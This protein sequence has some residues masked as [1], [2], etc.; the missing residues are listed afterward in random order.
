MFVN[1]E[2]KTTM[3]NIFAYRLASAR[4]MAGLSLQQLSDLLGTK[5]VSKQALNKYE[6][7]KMKPESS[8]LVALANALGVSVDYFFAKPNVK[9]V[10]KDV[11]YRKFITKISKPVQI[12]IEEKA[13]AQFERYFDLEE[14]LQL[15]DKRDYFKYNKPINTAKDAEEAAKTLRKQWDL[16]YDAVPDVVEML[17]DKGYKVIEL[18]AQEGFDGLSATINGEPVIALN[19]NKN[20]TFDIVRKRFSAL[21]ELAHHAL[22]FPDEMKEKEQEKLCHAFASAVLYPEEMAKKELHKERFHFYEKELILLKERWGLSIAAIFSRAKQ[23]GIINDNTY[24]RF[25]IGYR[26]RE[27]HKPGKE[28]GRFLSKE[29]PTRMERLV[30]LGLAKEVLSIN[31]AA[32]F[33]GISAWELRKQMD[34]L[35]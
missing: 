13:K 5:G 7:G 26:T 10:L 21:H 33:A 9:I 20:E 22:V 3:E 27:Y 30:F 4:K 18:D 1:N 16:G 24:R 23:L 19:K 11:E 8:V 6:Q 32:Y 34:Q 2:I 12:S 15:K 29:V 35:V 31:E 17:E 28:P 25:N 14:I